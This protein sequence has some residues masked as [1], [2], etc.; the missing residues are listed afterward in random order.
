MKS[1]S[2]VKNMSQLVKICQGIDNKALG[3]L[4]TPQG[5]TG[6]I[7]GT[8][9]HLMEVHF[10]GSK[11]AKE[12][13]TLDNADKHKTTDPSCYIDSKF[14]GIVTKDLVKAAFRQL[15]AAG[16]DEIK[17]IVLK[18]LP[19][20]HLIKSL[21]YIKLVCSSVTCH[22]VGFKHSPYGWI[23]KFGAF[24]SFPVHNLLCSR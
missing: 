7:S 21:R 11:V 17:P 13:W 23:F 10:P 20:L 4:E 16:P 22:K 1:I 2:N 15:K 18:N 3:M 9:R 24:F 5:M 19:T 12:T 14:K 6:S 8:L